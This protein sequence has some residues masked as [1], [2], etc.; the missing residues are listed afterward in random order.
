MFLTLGGSLAVIYSLIE[1]VKLNDLN[2][3]TYLKYFL[4]Q[5][6]D[7]KNPE[8]IQKLMLWNRDLPKML[9]PELPFEKSED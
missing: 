1:L 7:E 6:I 2:L 5:K 8:Q 4:G 3:E 9:D